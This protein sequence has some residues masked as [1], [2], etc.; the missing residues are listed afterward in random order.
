M[1]ELE[2]E[3]ERTR[4]HGR[5]LALVLCDVDDLKQIN[6]T[7]GHPGGDRALCAV[8]R[9]LRDSLRAG[10]T[11]FRI[12]GDE[13]AVLLPETTAEQAAIVATR[14]AAVAPRGSRVRCARL[15]CGVAAAPGDGDDAETLIARA[16]AALYATKRAR[17]GRLRGPTSSGREGRIRRSVGLTTP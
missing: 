6:D 7:Q 1:R 4:R 8:G 16:D 11:A 2:S 3:L 9:A 17:R 5:P 13:F 14:I 12:G 10:D 15:S